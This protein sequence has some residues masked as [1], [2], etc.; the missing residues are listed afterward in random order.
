MNNSYKKASSDY[1]FNYTEHLVQRKPDK[2]IILARVGII[3]LTVVLL[4]AVLVLTLKFIPHIAVVA[5]VLIAYITVLLWGLTKIEYEYLI[6]SGSMSMDKIIASKKRR[7]LTEFKVADAEQIAP[8]KEVRLDDASVIYAVSSVN[9][10]DAY[11]AV[12]R[13]ERGQKEAL[14][15]NATEKALTMLSYYN[16]TCTKLPK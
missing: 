9:D 14:V 13:N 15:F 11:C 2:N 1:A 12:Y 6:V 8:L 4:A 5:V 7:Q 10:E 16:K 3:A